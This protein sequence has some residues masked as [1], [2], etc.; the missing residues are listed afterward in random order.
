M[1]TKCHAPTAV[2]MTLGFMLA[3]CDNGSPNAPTSPSCAYTLSPSSLSFGASGG[4]SAVN[5]TTASQCTWSAVSDRG[6]M[7]ITSGSSGTGDGVVNVSVTPNPSE[8]LRTGTLTIAGQSVSVQEEG[9][10]V[11]ALEIWP[12][13]ASYNKD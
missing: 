10:G 2:L 1:R 8:A 13:G 9:L 6:W 12:S 3:A 4:T 7:S 5:V 11:C